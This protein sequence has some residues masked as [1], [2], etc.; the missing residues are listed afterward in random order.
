LRLP[1]GSVAGGGLLAVWLITGTVRSADLNFAS[2]DG[3]SRT[4]PVHL[5]VPVLRDAIAP[6]DVLVSFL[7]DG[8]PFYVYWRN[9]AITG[10]YFNG[11]E[12]KYVTARTASVPHEQPEKEAEIRAAME[13]SPRL[14]L[15]YRPRREMAWM[16]ELQAEIDA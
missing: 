14:W 16:P 9:D 6:D 3:G 8:L 7:P 10:F 12:F 4:F 13:G 5:L 15:A 2:V 11:I 1:F